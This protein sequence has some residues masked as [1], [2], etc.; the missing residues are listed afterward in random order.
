M[1]IFPQVRSL[2]E[3]EHWTSLSKSSLLHSGGPACPVCFECRNRRPFF[4][5]RFCPDVKIDFG[6]HCTKSNFAPQGVSHAKPVPARSLSGYHRPVALPHP[7]G[8]RLRGN[9]TSTACRALKG[10]GSKVSSCGA[11]HDRSALSWAIQDTALGFFWVRSCLDVDLDSVHHCTETLSI[12]RE[13]SLA[14]SGSRASLHYDRRPMML[15]NP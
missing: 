5:M 1:P 3:H 8:C 15:P 10:I 13:I 14:Y 7:Q 4:N 2:C 12:I 11:R 9:H 6:H